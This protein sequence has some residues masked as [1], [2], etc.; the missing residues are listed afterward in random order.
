MARVVIA[1]GSIYGHEMPE[2]QRLPLLH[3][4]SWVEVAAGEVMVDGT[5]LAMFSLAV[6]PVKVLPFPLE[7]LLCSACWTMA[8]SPAST[9]LGSTNKHNRTD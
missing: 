8:M 5:L 3:L 2:A 7:T 6:S 1:N 4:S 9:V